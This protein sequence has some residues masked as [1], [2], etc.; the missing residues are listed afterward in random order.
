MSWEFYVSVAG[1]IVTVLV[2][3]VGLAYWFGRRVERV[4]RRFERVEGG[5]DMLRAQLESQ[6][7]L[8]GSLIRILHKRKA[9]DDEEFREIFVAYSKMA[10]ARS[11]PFMEQELRAENPLTREEALRLNSYINKA[12]QGDFF[13][14]EE[15]EDYNALVRKLE[16]D[17]PNDP[18]V[19]PLIA[20]GA[21]LLGLYLAPQEK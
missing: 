10:T 21:F 7:T 19:W 3:A 4:E 2:S 11:S 14:S 20:L 15:V 16:Q 6:L 12:R 9:L 5:L 8:I 18:G 1:I 17:R 13:T